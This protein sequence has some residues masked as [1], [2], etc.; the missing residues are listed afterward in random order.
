MGFIQYVY[1]LPKFFWGDAE[2]G[3][4]RSQTYG[5][6][7]PPVRN[8]ELRKLLIW[9]GCKQNV[10]IPPCGKK[11]GL[12]VNMSKASQRGWGEFFVFILL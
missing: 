12:Y 3:L 4:G 9:R 8:S 10:F 6:S 11:Y 7:V 2:V 5:L 1:F